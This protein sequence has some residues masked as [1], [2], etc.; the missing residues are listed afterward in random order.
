MATHTQ[1]HGKVG[2]LGD[3]HGDLDWLEA[4]CGT[5]VRAEVSYII[6]VGDFQH[7]DHPNPDQYYRAVDQILGRQGL[8]CVFIGGNHEH[9]PYLRSQRLGASG[10]II[11]KNLT[12]ADRGWRWTRGDIRFVALGG[13]ATYRTAPR[14]EGVNWWPEDEIVRAEEVAAIVQAG[15]ADVLVCH[16][17]PGAV[18]FDGEQPFPRGE[19]TRQNL[20][21]AA[22]D[23]GVQLVLHGHLHRRMTNQIELAGQTIRVEGLGKAGQPVGAV[24]VLNL[25]DLTVTDLNGEEAREAA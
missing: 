4:A 19:E 10:Y 17:A 2:L 3:I 12:F 7:F 11:G 22:A 25:G 6:Q 15:P 8:R 1:S 13:A 24:A 18:R 14:T 21:V 9:F 5:L 20:N 23:L 16:D